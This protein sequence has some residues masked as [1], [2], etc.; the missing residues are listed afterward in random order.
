MTEQPKH[1]PNKSP[2]DGKPEEDL[3]GR[4]RLASNVI[5]N[6]AAYFVFIVAGFIMPRMIDRR[7]GQELLG[8]WDFAWSLVGYFGLVQMGVISSVNRYVAKHRADRDTFGMNQVTSSAS[9]ILSGA[10]LLVLGL[11]ITFSLLL[12][13][14]FGARLGQNMSD[15]QWVVFFLGMTIGI[16]MAFGVFNGILTG[17]HRWGLHNLIKSGWYLIMIV[18]MIV[19]LLKG[20]GLRS[21]AV[22]I[23]AGQ[24]LEETTRMTVAYRICEG[25]KIRPSLVKWKT[26]K[27][28]FVFGGK[29]LIPSI[30]NLLLNQT[31]SIMIIAY[32]GPAALALYARPRSLVLHVNTL[33]SKM[34]MTLTPTVS[35][36]QSTNNIKGI[37]GLLIASV[38]YSFYLVGPIVLVLI[39]FG[40]AVMQ[41]WMGPRYANHLIPA[42]L[43]VGY[44]TVFVQEPVL[45]ILAGLNAHG[46]AGIAKLV[47]SICSAGL[48]VLVL[49]YL[50]WGVAGAAVA[51]TLPLMIMSVVYL[52]FL[53]CRRVD[54]DVRQYFRSVITG[55]VVHI[56]PFAVCLIAGRFMFHDKALSG[57]LWGGLS[58]GV[59]L[60]VLYYRYVLPDRIRV[61]TRTI[62]GLRTS[63]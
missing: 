18:G 44:L 43:A 14:L 5:F 7:L 46:R 2:K 30:S 1:Q 16:Q 29:T 31:T 9:C 25:L 15:A 42:I 37:Q 63:S 36:L 47:A 12:P 26:A 41:F 62:F 48:T 49:G 3:T 56:F 55:P 53:V 20:G 19:A 50:K 6:W 28:L 57:L 22:V 13:Q 45:N 59:V 58:G 60:T 61:K 17:C 27:K 52:P 35:S 24:V 39:V 32:L 8:V 33:V 11:T 51:I 40:D 38:R 21:L 10:G 34:A 54:L 23:L 4:D